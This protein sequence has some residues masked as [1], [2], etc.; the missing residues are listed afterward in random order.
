M[1]ILDERNKTPHIDIRGNKDVYQMLNGKTINVNNLTIIANRNYIEIQCC[2]KP[3]VH[4]T[5]IYK[6]NII[7]D[8]DKVY[9]VLNKILKIKSHQIDI[10]MKL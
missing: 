5:L 7:A 9:E 2:I 4:L 3:A 8:I 1:S 6:D 10:K